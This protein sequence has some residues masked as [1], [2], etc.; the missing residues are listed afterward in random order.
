[1][2]CA[3]RRLTVNVDKT[4]IVVFERRRSVSPEFV[5]NGASVEQL[6]SSKYLGN[7]LQA[8]RSMWSA[9]DRLVL[10]GRRALFALRRRCA[11][12][13]IS[14]VEVSVV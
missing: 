6:E 9:V 13:R 5:Y 2:F 10:S 3:V 8:T 11:E 12:L 14:S 1:M 4:K 7:E